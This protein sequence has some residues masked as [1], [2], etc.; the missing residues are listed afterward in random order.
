[1]SRR[2]REKPD[3]ADI[4]KVAIKAFD[5]GAEGD[6]AVGSKIE[7]RIGYSDVCCLYW[8]RDRER[9][10]GYTNVWSPAFN[11]PHNLTMPAHEAEVLAARILSWLTFK[12]ALP[13]VFAEAA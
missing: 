5:C 12:A 4:T 7:L 1:M 8:W 13:K 10:S 3:P 2:R 11:G 9:W 6:R